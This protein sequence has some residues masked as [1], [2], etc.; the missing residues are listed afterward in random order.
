LAVLVFVACDPAEPQEVAATAISYTSIRISWKAGFNADRYE[1]QRS[2][3]NDG[4]FKTL[5]EVSDL[6]YKDCGLAPGTLYYYQVQS[7]SEKG[8]RSGFSTPAS[9]LTLSTCGCGDEFESHDSGCASDKVENVAKYCDPDWATL[10]PLGAVC[11]GLAAPEAAPYDPDAAVNPVAVLSLTGGID[12]ETYCMPELWK[13]DGID[14]AALVLCHERRETR[15]ERCHYESDEGK[16]Y[17]VNRYQ[18]AYGRRLHEAKTGVLI[19]DE[20]EK[21]TLP[22]ECPVTLERYFIGA[23]TISSEDWHGSDPDTVEWLEPYVGER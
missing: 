1:I 14:D 7:I 4:P 18:I 9:A 10:K 22:K 12:Q 15:L 6:A 11:A 5:A 17:T 23:A 3:D 16:K 8:E 21:G 19:V 20:V 13:P 2:T